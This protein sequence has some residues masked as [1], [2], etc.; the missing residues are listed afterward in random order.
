M[1][2]TIV[3]VRFSISLLLA[4][5][6]LSAAGPKPDP[7]WKKVKPRGALPARL[8]QLMKKA[9]RAQIGIQVVDLQR[10][11]VL[12]KAQEDRYFVPASNAKLLSTSLALVRLGPDYTMTTRV[13]AAKEPNEKG[14]LA[15]DIVLYGGGDPS[16]TVTGGVTVEATPAIADLAD[17]LIA[18]GVKRIRGGVIGD[19]T[20]WPWIPYGDAWTIDDAIW[21]YGAPVSA[22]SLHG[23]RVSVR[24]KPGAAPGDS[25]S[26][27]L[28]PALEYLTYDN[29]VITVEG[30]KAEIEIE[31]KPN[32]RL[33]V[34]KGTIGVEHPGWS[35]SL[36]IDDPALAAASA[37]TEALRLRGVAIDEQPEARHREPGDPA[38]V[39]PNVELARHISPPLKELLKTINKFSQNLGAE[40]VLR[41]TALSLTGDATPKNGVAQIKKL[42]DEAGVEEDD[43]KLQDGS[44]LSRRSLITPRAITTLLAYLY[45]SEQSALWRDMLPI[46]HFDGTLRNRF[47]GKEAPA[48]DI[49]RAKKISAKTGSLSTTV[50]LSGYADSPRGPLAFS[51]LVNNFY[52]GQEIRDFV[53]KLALELTR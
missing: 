21:D 38:P 28:L 9:P 45:R 25:T 17:Q 43:Y 23:N 37:L 5:G 50:A 36:A 22:L 26:V 19:D 40:I 32:T 52:D 2:P 24:V 34:I 11:K 13:L 8:S 35:E 1:L 18:K 15:G 10:N 6:L 49:E 16:L 48:K 33:V 20:L 42:L 46:G 51:I 30:R 3:R 44:G 29:R 41:Q 14:V 31:R 47:G 39:L 53:D 12:F 4:A 7:A 27:M